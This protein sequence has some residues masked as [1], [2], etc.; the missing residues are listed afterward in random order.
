MTS[1]STT[2][3]RRRHRHRWLD[4]DYT[5][6]RNGD[7]HRRRDR[8]RTFN[9]PIIKTASTRADESFQLTSSATSGNANSP[10]AT[11]TGTINDDETGPTLTIGNASTDRTERQHGFTVSNRQR[12][13]VSS[14][15]FI[16]HVEQAAR[17]PA[18]EPTTHSTRRNG[19]Y[20]RA[21]GT[22]TTVNV[23]IV[24]DTIDEPNETFQLTVTVTSGNAT[25][26]AGPRHRNHQRR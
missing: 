11:A 1:T 12:Y 8:Q 10:A 2:P 5:H 24:D 22:S 25:D 4:T 9:V 19:N 3:P 26:P 14:D 18:V 7:Y 20:R 23:P 17:P 16:H 21:G 15:L 6:R 13:P